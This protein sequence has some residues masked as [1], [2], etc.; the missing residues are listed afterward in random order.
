M[1]FSDENQHSALS[2]L[3]KSEFKKKISDHM[4]C[5]SV[6]RPHRNMPPAPALY[7]YYKQIHYY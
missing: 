4:I 1:I 7:L 6:S 5:V 3:F 2:K